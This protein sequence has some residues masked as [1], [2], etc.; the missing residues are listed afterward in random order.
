MDPDYQGSG[1]GTKLVESAEAWLGNIPIH[2]EVVTYNHKAITFYKK[3]GFVE[4]SIP[5]RDPII[6]KSGKRIPEMT[7]MRSTT[8]K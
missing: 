1:L 8:S 4:T 2:L 5:P 6:L 3:L 7:M